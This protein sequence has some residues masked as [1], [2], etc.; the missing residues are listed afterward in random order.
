MDSFVYIKNG[1][2]YERSAAVIQVG[3]SLKR[4][5]S[6]AVVFY[7][8]PPFMRNALYDFVARHRYRWF[9]KKDECMVPTEHLK[10]RFLE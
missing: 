7:L 5:Y 2:A 4:W 10:S 9:G 8:F 1:K 6:L 3:L